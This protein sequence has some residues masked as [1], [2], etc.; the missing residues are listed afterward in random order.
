LYNKKEVDLMKRLLVLLVM[1]TML[2]GIIGVT[3]VAPDQ[4]ANADVV[5]DPT[6][7]PTP[8]LYLL[9]V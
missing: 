6:L 1:M 9:V 7:T 5:F 8:D 2:L 4:E 3:A